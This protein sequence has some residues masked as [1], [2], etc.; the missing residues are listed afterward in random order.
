MDAEEGEM[1]EMAR[2]EDVSVRAWVISCL[3]LTCAWRKQWCDEMGFS[4]VVGEI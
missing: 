4:S 3:S 1:E 2:E